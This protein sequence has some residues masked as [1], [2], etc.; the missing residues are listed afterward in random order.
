MNSTPRFTAIV[1][2]A[3]RHPK[4]PVAQAAGVSCKALCSLGDTPMVLHVLEALATSDFVDARILCG[5]P[6]SV[7]EQN[8]Q[9]QSG[10]DSGDFTWVMNQASP[11]ASA[12]N[13]MQ[14]LP[15][16]API[17]LT[18]ADHALLTPDMV[19]YFC[20]QAQAS[21][22]DAVAALALYSR[23]S[24]AYPG[25]RR[26]VLK[27]RDQ[28]YCGCNLFAFLTPKGRTVAKFWRQLE[29]HRKQPLKMMGMIGWR[30]AI[31][32]ALGRLSLDDGLT[33]LSRRLHLRL[34]VIIMPFPEAAIDVDNLT[35]LTFV[36][37]RFNAKVSA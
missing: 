35:D 23:V 21:G 10:I 19:D 27:F 3:D 25:V 34:G 20:T 13:A 8:T 22:C 12:Y 7:I 6:W 15:E 28:A 5:P 33:W 2:A 1:L 18:T 26:T 31:R 24:A 32:Y 14:S 37:R 17:L 16:K 4:D 11:S 36:Q 29:H 9:L 30:V